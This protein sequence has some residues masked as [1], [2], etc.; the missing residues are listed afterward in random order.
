MKIAVKFDTAAKTYDKYNLVQKNVVAELLQNLD[1][2]GKD[3]IDLGCGEGA[4]YKSLKQTPKSFTAID[5]SETMLSLHPKNPNIRLLCESFDEHCFGRRYDLLLSASALQWSKN[6]ESLA[7]KIAESTEEIA[8]AIF[9]SESMREIHDFLGIAS[10]LKSA[11]ELTQIFQSHFHVNTY[12]KRYE[13]VFENKEA[14]FTYIKHS[15]IGGYN[16]LSYKEA[17]R[18]VKDFDGLVLGFEVL[19]IF[20]KV[21]RRT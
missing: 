19:Y 9:T 16:L 11:R 13:L 18:L 7:Y 3:I 17:K 1:C 10:P 14:L 2:S 21:I 12:A 8:L 4:L 5:R 15:G 6:L 20:G